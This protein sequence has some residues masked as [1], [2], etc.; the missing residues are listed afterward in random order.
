MDEWCIRLLLLLL[1]ELWPPTLVTIPMASVEGTWQELVKEM[2]LVI[3]AI[4]VGRLPFVK[5]EKAAYISWVTLYFLYNSTN[6]SN[7]LPWSCQSISWRDQFLLICTLCIWDNSCVQLWRRIWTEWRRCNKK[8]WRRHF[9]SI[10]RVGWSSPQLWRFKS[11]KRC[12]PLLSY[13][14]FQLSSVLHWVQSPMES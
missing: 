9:K 11:C 13:S 2:V 5:V 10:W 12:F 4:G 6:T 14:F 7:H 3:M 8:L 1:M